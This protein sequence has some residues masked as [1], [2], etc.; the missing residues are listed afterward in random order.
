MIKRLIMIFEEINLMNY[1][2]NKSYLIRITTGLTNVDSL[3]VLGIVSQG[4]WRHE[5]WR[6]K[7]VRKGQHDL[8]ITTQAKTSLIKSIPHGI[9]CH[10]Q[11]RY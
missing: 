10:F 1:S 5:P 6:R 8:K 4:S 7:K 9:S 3:C 11:S 2:I